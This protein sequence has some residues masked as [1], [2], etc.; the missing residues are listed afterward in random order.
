[1]KK[2]IITLFLVFFF[3]SISYAAVDRVIDP[4]IPIDAALVD[5]E[6]NFDDVLVS[7]FAVVVLGAASVSGGVFMLLL[8]YFLI[9]GISFF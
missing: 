6:Q 7:V 5:Y 9:K 1:M 8:S 2:Q 3:V 4:E